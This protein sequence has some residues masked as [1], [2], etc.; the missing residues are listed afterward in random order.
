MHE[1]E[2]KKREKMEEDLVEMME[3]R[4][5]Q[6]RDEIVNIIQVILDAIYLG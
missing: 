2:K 3:L 1:K 4:I 6:R 5:Q